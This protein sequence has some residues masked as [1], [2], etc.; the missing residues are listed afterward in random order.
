MFGKLLKF[1]LFLHTRQISFWIAVLVMTLFG[2]LS[3]S[4]DFIT[5]SLEGGEKVKTNGALPLALQIS[6]LSLLSLFFAA[7]FVVNGVMRDETHKTLEII[8]ATPINTRDMVISRMIGAWAATVLCIIAA[9]IGILAGQFAPWADQE[10]F[11]PFN[12][13]YY[14]HPLLVFAFINALLVTGIYTVIAALS[15]NKSIV[16]V[17]AVGLLAANIGTELFIGEDGSD[18]IT[19][20]ADPFGFAP[21]ELTAEFWPAAEQ[22]TRLVPLD[23]LIGLNRLVWSLA[24]L[25]MFALAFPFFKRGTHSLN[26]K[27]KT[28]IAEAETGKILLRPATQTQGFGTQFKGFLKRFA[29]EYLTTVRSIAFMILIGIALVLFGINVY[30]QMAFIPDPILPTS[31]QMAFTVLGSFGLSMLI[32]I[33]FFGGEII[34][35]DRVAGIH[36]IIDATPVHNASLL[37]AKWLALMAVIASLI[38]VGMTFGMIMQLI[39]GGGEIPVNIGVYLKFGFMTFGAGFLLQAIMAMFVQNFTPNRIFGM[40]LAAGVLILFLFIINNLP[41]FH[42]LM[43]YGS[44]GAGQPSEMSGF[45]DLTRFKWFFLYWGSLA[46][47]MGVLSVWMWRRGLQVGLIKRIKDIS[48]RITPASGGL[49]ALAL[50]G[51]IGSGAYI[52]KSYNIDNDYRNSKANERRQVAYEKLVKP[53]TELPLPMVRSVEADVRFFPSK[54]EALIGGAYDIENATDEPI[55][56][57]YLNMPTSHEEDVRKLEIAGARYIT[58]GEHTE[59]L[60]EHSIREYRFDPPL[61]PGHESRITFETFYHA[62]RLGDGSRIDRNGTFLNNWSTMPSLGINDA[63]GREGTG[64]HRYGGPPAQLYFQLIRLC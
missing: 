15:R 43:D 10:S 25:A 45:R 24:G 37:S 34:W 3:S 14:L 20:L 32:I 33:V 36:E 64:P 59:D 18:L 50:A 28:L 12:I 38:I 40:L 49:A 44:L 55:S 2:F 4:T 27:G 41:F 19:S 31:T 29:F 11:G 47:L 63:G 35:R 57:L 51:F 23:G 61:A 60:A 5:L 62:P 16:Y 7:V 8:H 58:D 53:M 22:N 17:S 30:A 13:I 56:T 39:I 21:L 1:E 52:F 48:K 54:R 46:L 6:F 42:P 26:R 9:V